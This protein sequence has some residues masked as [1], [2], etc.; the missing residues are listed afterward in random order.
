MTL[1]IPQERYAQRL[2]GARAAGAAAGL[3]ALL[4]GVGADLRYLAGY[5]AHRWSE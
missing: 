2:A 3:D 4:V 1:G 5:H